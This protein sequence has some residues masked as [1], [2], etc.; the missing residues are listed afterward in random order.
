[1]LF[2]FTKSSL[3]V[4]VDLDGM[5]EDQV[6]FI[7]GGG[8]SLLKEDLSKLT[9]PG[10]FVLAINNTPAMMPNGAVNAWIGSDKPSCYSKR[11]LLDPTIVKF[12]V[13]SRKDL[14]VGDV[15][16][17]RLPNTYFF[18]TNDKFNEDNFLMP[19]RDFLWWK[20]TFFGALQLVHRLGF[21]KVYLIGCGFKVSKEEQ[22]SYSFKLDDKERR[23]NERLYSQSVVRMK[24]L[25]PIMDAGGYKVISATKG[26]LLNGFYPVVSFDDAVQDAV[27]RMPKE[28]EL[29]KCVHSSAFRGKK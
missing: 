27:D 11:I 26:S 5:F 18:G 4:P 29:E 9:Q 14:E 28:Y 22:Y 8:P 16:W 10:V 19:H 17:K 1:M 13:I 2:R 23:I 25:K 7:A 20:N 3:R 24:K 15:E 12:T 6:A 21:R